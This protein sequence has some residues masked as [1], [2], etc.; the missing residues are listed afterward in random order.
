[1]TWPISNHESPDVDLSIPSVT[2]PHYLWA[3]LSADGTNF[4]EHNYESTRAAL[5][6]A[7]DRFSTRTTGGQ[8]PN[9]EISEQ[10]L[11]TWKT[12][13]E[14]M[15]LL[16]VDEDGTVQATR[17]GRAVVD[18]LNDVAASLEGANHKIAR[19]GAMVANRVLLAKPDRSGNPASGVPAGADLRPLRAIWKAFR[20]L[21]NRLH[22]QDINRVLGHIHNEHELESAISRI[23]EFRKRFPTGYSSEEELKELGEEVLTNDPRH[24]TPWFNRAGLGGV[25]IPS[26]AASDGFRTLTDENATIL[27]SLLDE[28]VPEVPRDAWTYRA[29]YISYLM[30]PVEAA[31]RPPLATA[32]VSLVQEVLA[33]VRVHGARK[34]VALSG[35]PGTGKTRLAR[36]VADQ[37]TDGDPSRSM[38]IQFHDSTSYEDF[39]EGF[40]P[41][42]DGQGF[43]LRPK[44]LRKINEKALEDP[45]REYV[46]LI[47]EFT[48][49]NAHSVLGELLTYIEHRSRKFTLSISQSETQIA[50]N[51]IVI[52]TMNPRDRSALS[53]DDAVN[54][55]VHRIPVPSS[56]ASLKEMLRSSLSPEVLDRLVD[57]F[58]RHL[59]DLPFG[60]G[61]FAH[62]K[63][64]DALADIFHG[65]VQPLLSDPLGRVH[66]AYEAAYESFPYRNIHSS[67]GEIRG[68]QGS[69]SSETVDPPSIDQSA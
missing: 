68:D 7:I 62:A 64:T 36:I 25:L 66:E 52:T 33:A 2:A 28:A 14:E 40:V 50:P 12:A 37:I 6:E 19:L 32:D 39:V 56:V 1:M 23:A 35:I 53:L 42:A 17:F 47:E 20:Q 18:G 27:D 67:E 11:R 24:I 29:A 63:D 48:R 54:R 22:W 8:T 16:T 31:E 9:A 5:R 65:T 21:G 13:F 3:I 55:R 69:R 43:Q 45:G 38:E 26:E 57:W 46:L 49:A 61:V 60:H 58:D 41:R 51:L 4:R 15:G 44:T 34:I 10:R 59:D 30:S